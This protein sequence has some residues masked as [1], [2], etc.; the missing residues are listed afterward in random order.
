MK[1]LSCAGYAWRIITVHIEK[2]LKETEKIC[3]SGGDV[4]AVHQARVASRR[5][6]N[7]FWVF[8]DMLPEKKLKLWREVL[9]GGAA[10]LGGARD[11]DI[12]I[13]F[14]EG[15]L[16]D[17]GKKKY[18]DELSALLSYLTKKRTAMKQ[19][20]MA[21][22][23]GLIKSGVLPMIVDTVRELSEKDKKNGRMKL[24]SLAKDRIWKR[25]TALL[26][27]DVYVRQSESSEELHKMRIAAKKLRYTLENFAPLYGKRTERY[28]SSAH[29]LQDILGEL[30]DL[31]VWVASFPE[32]AA[33]Y[34]KAGK[35]DAGVKWFTKKCSEKRA[36]VYDRFIELWDN[37]KL[38]G[39]W[40][41]L[42]SFVTSFDYS[43]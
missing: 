9:R 24:Y 5:L 21:I 39:E 26:A 20:L 17:A 35:K 4:E 18:R 43:M 19:D 1:H 23:G 31:D 40:E 8:G 41:D 38:S 28:I 15:F 33:E 14:I 29:A 7:S 27:Y 11:L 3:L 37:I 36:V 13:L 30:H 2:L 22:S 25:L 16:G 42:A 10:V 12:Q 6:R 32:L 34:A